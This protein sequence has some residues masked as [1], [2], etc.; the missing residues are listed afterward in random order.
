MSETKT[1]IEGEWKGRWTSGRHEGLLYCEFTP[2]EELRYRADFHAKYWKFF[3]FKYSM[4]I[5]F[6]SEDDG[7]RFEGEQDVGWWAGG[8]YKY[9]GRVHG[10]E[11]EASYDSKRNQG[12]FELQKID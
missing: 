7:Y 2:L 3:S 4:E 1:T 11:L 5:E 9:Q 6:E 10:E 8:L 12:T